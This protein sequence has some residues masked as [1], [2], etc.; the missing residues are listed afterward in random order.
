MTSLGR[1]KMK[2]VMLCVVAIGSCLALVGCNW[3]IG[4]SC[5]TQF[6]VT[7]EG[8][9]TIKGSFDTQARLGPNRYSSQS[10]I[11]DAASVSLDTTGSTMAYPSQGQITVSLIN[12]TNGV[13]VAARTFDWTRSGSIL[14]FSNPVLVN[15]WLSDYSSSGA[16]TATYQLVPFATS[17][18]EGSNTISIAS[19]YAG[20]TTASASQT[21][22]YCPRTPPTPG[23][24]VC[25]S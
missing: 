3:E 5:K 13:V 6:S 20:T 4:V 14:V 16:D 18:V 8:H 15:S 23:K 11:L 9:G 2:R 19:R 21:F 12:S 17:L 25:G 10:L 22:T 7:C 1:L 24:P